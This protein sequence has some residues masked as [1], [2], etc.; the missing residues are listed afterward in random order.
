MIGN[1]TRALQKATELFDLDPYNYKVIELF[2]EVVVISHNQRSL[3]Q[4]ITSKKLDMDQY[5]AASRFLIGKALSGMGN[6][7]QSEREFAAQV[8]AGASSNRMQEK[9]IRNLAVSLRKIGKDKDAIEFLTNMIDG[10]PQL[11]RNSSILDLRAKSKIELAKRCMETARDRNSSKEI[12]GRA[13]DKCRQ[14]LNEAESDL[15]AAAENCSNEY[16]QEFIKNDLSFLNTLKDI[17]RKPQ[18]RRNPKKGNQR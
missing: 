1:H 2:C 16:E 9:E 17:A 14:Y 3:Y 5:S 12:K 18:N 11:A 15:Y 10:S 13:W 4:A 7:T 8:L 6:S